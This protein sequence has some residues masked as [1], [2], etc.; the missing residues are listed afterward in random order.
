MCLW[1]GGGFGVVYERSG[2]VKMG[3]V[4]IGVCGCCIMFLECVHFFWVF[5]CSVYWL[6]RL[7]SVMGCVLSAHWMRCVY[8]LW[9]LCG[10]FFFHVCTCFCLRLSP[11]LVVGLEKRFLFWIRV[12]FF[13]L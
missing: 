12:D 7:G 2:C 13:L 3:R 11:G 6:S 10:F 4:L 1:V 8:L 5:A 9:W